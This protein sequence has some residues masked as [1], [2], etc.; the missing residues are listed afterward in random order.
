LQRSGRHRRGERSAEA[1]A[2]RS[3][4]FVNDLE[5]VVARRHP[6]IARIVAR[7]RAGGASHAAMT[8]SGS[9]VIGVFA[10]QRSAARAARACTSRSQVVLVTQTLNRVRY[11]RLA[12]I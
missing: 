4:E 9:T 6:A 11:Q 5:P 8:G 3:Q 12:A 10:S 1:F 7:L 2:L